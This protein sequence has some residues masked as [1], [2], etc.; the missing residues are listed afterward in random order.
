V[1]AGIARPTVQP[2]RIPYLSENKFARIVVRAINSTVIPAYISPC[3][4]SRHRERR[5]GRNARSNRPSG[6][7]T[8]LRR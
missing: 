7:C 2:L 1:K 3:V 5:H 4:S 8:A 6:C